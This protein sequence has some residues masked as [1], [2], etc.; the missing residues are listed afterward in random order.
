MGTKAAPIIQKVLK[1]SILSQKNC[2]RIIYLKNLDKLF[3][4]QQLRITSHQRIKIIPSITK[5]FKKQNRPKRIPSKHL[6]IDI[7]LTLN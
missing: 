2:M 3:L 6:I 1:C 4:I 5:C 7:I